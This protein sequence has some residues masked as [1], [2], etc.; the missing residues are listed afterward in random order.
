VINPD[1]ESTRSVSA[2]V[3]VDARFQNSAHDDGSARQ[4]GFKSALVP[5]PAVASFMSHMFVDAWGEAWLR[6]G[7]LIE[8]QRR[9][10]YEA[11]ALTATA[12]PQ[13]RI[14]DGIGADIVLTNEA[15]EQVAFA[16]G[17]LPDTAPAAPDLA[18]YPL[19][20]HFETPPKIGRGDLKVGDLYRTTPFV[21]TDALHA[22]Y[23]DRVRETLP[24]YAADGVV[25][26]GY[27]VKLTMHDAVGS[28]ERPTPGVHVAVS[29]Q[30]YDLA[31]VGETLSSSGQVTAVYEKNGN[32]YAESDQLVIANG[33]RP[34]AMVHRT[35]ISSFAPKV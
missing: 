10:V 31:Y 7:R 8:R 17:I 34:I 25:H 6:R 5:G 13:R 22:D 28:Y 12:T 11:Q 2:T 14:E 23:L 15:G 21:Y 32:W 27:L 33:L 20:A 16:T 26:P 1:T 30:H 19:R 24:F 3:G 4:L 9:P 35:S 18:D 29:V